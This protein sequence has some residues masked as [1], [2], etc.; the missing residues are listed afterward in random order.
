MEQA[1]VPGQRHNDCPPVEQI[2]AQR[3]PRT[4]HIFDSFTGMHIPILSAQIT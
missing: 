2:N 3:I 1:R 4:V